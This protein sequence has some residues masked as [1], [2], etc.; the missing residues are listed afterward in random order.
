MQTTFNLPN[1]QRKAVSEA[2]K[3]LGLS[4]AAVIR[5]ALTDW[6]RKECQQHRLDAG[7]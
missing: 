5:L 6:L 7:R 2:G 3:R 4:M 1:R